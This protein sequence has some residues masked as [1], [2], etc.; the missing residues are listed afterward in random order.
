MKKFELADEAIRLE[1]EGVAV[2]AILPV[3]TLK[4]LEHYSREHLKMLNT[5]R[6]KYQDPFDIKKISELA[7]AATQE[8]LRKHGL[9]ER[10]DVKLDLV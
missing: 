7:I 5:I 1:K 6:A 9:K 2:E 4:T 8:Q 3:L 10:E